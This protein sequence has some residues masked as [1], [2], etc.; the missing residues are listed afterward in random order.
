MHKTEEWELSLKRMALL[1]SQ[2]QRKA[3]TLA[4]TTKPLKL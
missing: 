3:D 2:Y 1:V 4:A